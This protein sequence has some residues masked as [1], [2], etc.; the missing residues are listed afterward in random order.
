MV[1]DSYGYQKIEIESKRI[2]STTSQFHTG[3]FMTVKTLFYNCLGKRK[4]MYILSFK[5]PMAT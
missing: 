2:S 5:A 3:L 4:N 1:L